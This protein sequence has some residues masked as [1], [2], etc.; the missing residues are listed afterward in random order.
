MVIL[1]DMDE[2]V[3]A[4]Q[5]RCCELYNR[6]NGTNITEE[7]LTSWEVGGRLFNKYFDQDGLYLDLE[8]L[9][10]SQR[11]L[12]R[13]L[14]LGHHVF[15]VTAPSNPF[16]MVEKVKWV[17]KHFP[18]IGYRNMFFTKHKGMVRGD[19]LIDDSPVFLEQFLGKGTRIKMRKRYNDHITAEFAV[20]HWLEIESILLELI[21]E[22]AIV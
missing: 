3:A 13:M 5:K 9:E 6:D 17:E 4:L 11:V 19:V 20:N 22:K 14:D 16:S 1:V 7:D 18:F 15:F 10:D 21:A 8:V 12:Q 2:V